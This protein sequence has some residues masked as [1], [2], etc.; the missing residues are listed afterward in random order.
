MWADPVVVRYIGGRPSTP[1][2]C[3]MR[4]LSYRGCWSLLGYGYWA[5]CELESG[6]YVGD[7]GFADFHRELDE[8]IRGI[9]EAGW[10]LVPWAHGKGFATEALRA[11][12]AWL[13]GQTRH[14]RSVCLIA[15][16]NQ[17][18]I[19]I[20]E[21]TGFRDPAPVRLN[22]QSALRYVRERAGA[23]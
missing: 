23:S 1:R 3:W 11:A 5:I 8:P 12:L 14:A 4:M 17:V 13:D 7:V 6:R 9:P 15:P 16:D 10:A 19:R 21:K 22:E 18:S 2:E 20:A